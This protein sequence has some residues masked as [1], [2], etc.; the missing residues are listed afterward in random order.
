MSNVQ[1]VNGGQT[2]NALFE[3]YQQNPEKID[4]VVLL[5]R[6]Y[7]TRD[8]EISIHIAESTN[9]Q[10]PIKSR[11][12]RANDFIQR[13]LEETFRDME[14]YYERKRGQYRNQPREQR[15]DLMAAAQA[16]L[17]YYLE[18]PEVAKK[19]KARIVGDQYEDIFNE[20]ITAEVM[21]T[22]V[23]LM[24]LIDQ[25]KRELQAKIRGGGAF[26]AEEL[27]LIDGGYHVLYMISLLCD[28]DG[29]TPSNLGEARERID[30]AIQIVGGVVNREM[31][32]SPAFTTSRFFKDAK[33]KR[34][35][36]QELSQ[37]IAV[38]QGSVP[39]G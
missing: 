16:Y 34:V 32:G 14:Y 37:A 24:K 20:D 22:P 10:T 29:V 12:L 8:R 19:D 38:Q 9:S 13:Q 6:I 31:R 35:L 11:D 27:C 33:T 4:G 28:Q 36:Q 5:V 23:L 18:Q 30:R 7:E 26:E 21:L 3:A 15:I 39:S 25:K 1:I 17:A 2:S